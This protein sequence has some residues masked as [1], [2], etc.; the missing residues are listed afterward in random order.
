MLSFIS[1]AQSQ[2]KKIYYFCFMNFSTEKKNYQDESPIYSPL[3]IGGYMVALLLQLLINY[4]D[5]FLDERK[6]FN[7]LIDFKFNIQK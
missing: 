1:V 3:V 2:D 5:N 4:T 7:Y 6:C